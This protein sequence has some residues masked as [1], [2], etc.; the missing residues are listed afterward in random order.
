MDTGLTKRDIFRFLKVYRDKSLRDILNDD[1][2]FLDSV[3]KKAI[4]LYNKLPPHVVFTTVVNS[5]TDISPANAGIH[6]T[7]PM[8][9]SIREN[10][11]GGEGDTDGRNDRRRDS[12]ND[13]GI[14]L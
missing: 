8:D 4:A 7:R 13:S 2:S 9:S 14:E 1:K 11:T 10:D 3:N 12:R 5:T 6:K